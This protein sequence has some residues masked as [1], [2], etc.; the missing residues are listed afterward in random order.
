[1]N[2]QIVKKRLKS[3]GINA[4]LCA[5]LCLLSAMFAWSAHHS[6]VQMLGKN[7]Q[8]MDVTIEAIS[9]FDSP[10]AFLAAFGGFILVIAKVIHMFRNTRSDDNA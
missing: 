7:V 3:T 5:I 6:F 10:S 2:R 9:R 4:G 1:M 8:F